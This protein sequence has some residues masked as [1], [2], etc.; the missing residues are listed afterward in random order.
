MPDRAHHQDIGNVPTCVE[1]G[2]RRYLVVGIQ[3]CYMVRYQQVAIAHLPLN[4]PDDLVKDPFTG[5]VIAEAVEELRL[6]AQQLGRIVALLQ[7]YAVAFI[8]V[9]QTVTSSDL[10]I[11]PPAPITSSSQCATTTCIF[12]YQHSKSRFISRT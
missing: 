6:I 11:S 5:A 1:R 2:L 8:Q 4:C 3:V 9:K 12:I 10:L 7:P